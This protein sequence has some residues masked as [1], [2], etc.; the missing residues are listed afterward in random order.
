MEQWL[1]SVYSDGS[2]CFV[3]KQQPE[4]GETVKI[5]IRMY[6]EAPVKA[7]ILRTMPNGA[8]TMT[9]MKMVRTEKG[10]TYYEAEVKMQER[11]L[12]YHFYL[13]CEDCIYYYNQRGVTTY[14]PDDS[15]DFVLL[16]EYHQPSW[17][18]KAVFYQIFPERFCNGNPDNDVQDGEYTYQG[19]PTIRRTDWEE[20]PLPYQ[21]GY[22]LDFSGGDL[23]GIKEKIPYLKELGVTALYLNPIFRAPSV[24]KYDCMDY[25]HVDPHFGGDK[26][27]VEL[28]EALHANDMKLILDISI[29]HVGSEH[30]WFNKEAQFWDKSQG[31]YQNPNCEEREFFFFDEAQNYHGWEGY[32]S[33]PTLNYQSEALRDLIYRAQ[34]SV[35]KKWLKPPY[36]IDGWRFDV[37]DVFGRNNQVQL[38]RELW[39]AIRQSIREENP[40]AYI[41]AEHWC[42]CTKYLQGEEWDS[43]MNYFGC[44]RVLREFIGIPDFFMARNPSIRQTAHKIS[45]EDVE[46]RVMQYLAKL[47]F[48]I[49]ENQFNLLDSHDC[50]R[51]HNYDFVNPEECR[52]AVILQ[53][54]LIGTPSV[55]YGDEVGIDGGVE[56]D[57]GYR[58]PMPWSQI[59]GRNPATF[60]FYQ[61]LMQLKREKKALQ[62]G[63]MKFLYAKDQIVALARFAEDEAYI[64]VMSASDRRQKIRLPLKAIGVNPQTEIKEVFGRKLHYTYGKCGEADRLQAETA[65]LQGQLMESQDPTGC[66]DDK[67]IWLEV[68]PHQ[69]YLLECR[70]NET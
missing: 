64:A 14:M 59:P 22:S 6:E 40:E 42:D 44:G 69:A 56:G 54:L 63:G 62:E 49:W 55:Y 16:S 2:A 39:P 65:M 30:R 19:H 34:D 47:P 3:S 1:E 11:R 23:E 15:C 8:D 21:K 45:A 35:L 66:A 41:L 18:K 58:Y 7:V 4:L 38:D 60:A 36:C 10:L 61:K 67:S 51:M 53:F 46:A 25:F 29:N 9:E 13:V 12:H 48:A 68:E 32:D 52:G 28:A 37:A 27:L 50:P 57:E 24:H 5:R 31:A 26:A 17:V 20:A 33:L 70:M 43:P